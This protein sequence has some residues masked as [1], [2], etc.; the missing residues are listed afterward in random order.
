MADDVKYC[1]GDVTSV[2]L[3]TPDTAPGSTI[4]IG[5]KCYMK[6]GNEGSITH[7][8]SAIEATHET[9]CAPCVSAHE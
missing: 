7:P 6:T 8:L 5:G 9:T 2:F 1:H 4:V 3:D